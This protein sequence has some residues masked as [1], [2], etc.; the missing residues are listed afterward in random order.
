MSPRF[1]KVLLNKMLAFLLFAGIVLSGC[2]QSTSPSKETGAFSVT[3]S[4]DGSILMVLDFG[5]GSAPG[6]ID[7]VISF[8]NPTSAPMTGFHVS[9]S[10]KTFQFKG[11]S[12]PGTGGT[13]GQTL[14]PNSLCTVVVST[15]AGK[16]AG[17]LKTM[18]SALQQWVSFESQLI[19]D[20]VQ[21]GVSKSNTVVLRGKSANAIS[22]AADQTITVDENNPTNIVLSATDTDGEALT[23]SVVTQPS[24]GTLSGTI[25]NLLY[26]PNPDFSGN[27]SFTFNAND[28]HGDSNVAKIWIT[29]N[30]V[31]KLEIAANNETQL[32]FGVSGLNLNPIARTLQISN[33]GSRRAEN[34]QI[35]GLQS[36]FRFSQN[37]TFPGSGGTCAAVLEAGQ[38]CSIVFDFLATN[39]GSFTSEPSVQYFDGSH[40]KAISFSLTGTTRAAILAAPLSQYFGTKQLTTTNE[41]AITLTN[42]GFSAATN[43]QP[44]QGGMSSDSPSNEFTFKDGTYPG[45]GG[46]C[47]NVLAAGASCTVIVNFKPVFEGYGY[48]MI[49][50]S[51]NDGNTNRPGMMVASLSGFG[52][53][54]AVLSFTSSSPTDF[55]NTAI[56][57]VSEKTVTLLHVSGQCPGFLQPDLT[58]L[59]A[60][61]RFKGGTFPGTGGTCAYGRGTSVA[62]SCTMVLELAL[63]ANDIGQKSAALVLGYNSCTGIRTISQTLAGQGIVRLTLNPA[64]T[65]D[66]GLI[67][68]SQ[69][70]DQTVT[71]TNPAAVSVD[72][73]KGTGLTPPFSF[74]GGSWPGTGGTCSNQLGPNQSCTAVITF[75]PTQPGTSNST[76]LVSNIYAGL[77]TDSAPSTLSGGAFVPLAT[78]VVGTIDFGSVVVGQS[79]TKSITLMNSS[80]VSL[81]TVSFSSLHAPFSYA[82]G[83]FP[84]TGGNCSTSIGAN[85]NCSIVIQ[86]SPLR[87]NKDS[88]SLHLEGTENGVMVSLDF[89]LS[90]IGIIHFYP[91]PTWVMPSG[92]REFRSLSHRRM[93]TAIAPDGKVLYPVSS[94]RSIPL[95]LP[96]QG[97]MTLSV[98][99][100]FPDGTPDTAFNSKASLLLPY[101]MGSLQ[102]VALAPNG[103]VVGVGGLDPVQYTDNDLLFVRFNSQGIPD[104]SLEYDSAKGA[105]R[106]S[107]LGAGTQLSVQP[108][109]KILVVFTDLGGYARLGRLNTDG[110]KDDSFQVEGN[111]I[112]DDYAMLADGSFLIAKRYFEIGYDHFGATKYDLDGNVVHSFGDSGNGSVEFDPG[113]NLR[114]VSG[115][116]P[117][118]SVS[119]NGNLTV[120]TTVEGGGYS[121]C[122]GTTSYYYQCYSG[123]VRYTCSSQ[124]CSNYTAPQSA[125][126]LASHPDWLWHANG[127][128]ALYSTY[129]STG[130][131]ILNSKFIPGLWADFIAYDSSGNLFFVRNQIYQ[132][133]IS[134]VSADGT[135]VT[136]HD[137]NNDPTHFINSTEIFEDFRFQ[138]DGKPII[139]AQLPTET[140]ANLNGT[141]F[142]LWRLWK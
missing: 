133:V 1:Q 24:S 110:A 6:P 3:L 64:P 60:P 97:S 93:Q 38:T 49:V 74:K 90:A 33:S 94:S 13:C 43:I 130:H 22:V 16:T 48:A 17:A 86:Y 23:F 44:V 108:S 34:I 42:V 125:S 66:F 100:V 83:T 136:S 127:S 73:V 102:S 137:L 80:S 32:N 117:T 20:F 139:F 119:P 30:P 123:G 140:N 111:P 128:G 63:G 5:D 77:T 120:G 41:L 122:I 21:D 85:S 11:E 101:S 8:N 109:G 138:S 46:T 62:E 126:D 12:Y 142:Y 55:G 25:P 124:V 28:G 4:G 91:D 118:L 26:I 75:A 79:V 95:S 71:I 106:V 27:D 103:D 15:V 135:S 39:D 121:R 51:Y 45:N 59:P 96:K 36:P 141:N 69:P 35:T 7:R 114:A 70:K 99:R 98:V 37:T 10:D 84:G 92:G 82:G 9:V 58:S 134:Q 18:R 131:V 19:I 72:A 116:L 50:L 54:P 81:N 56:G 67:E 57:N 68:Q 104:P 105:K 65:I 40:Q 29:V 87:T 47:G 107:G 14:A 76:L 2:T 89:S 78:S 31:A 53:T 112:V 61:F 129:D 132:H 88:G 115:S 52:F 113:L